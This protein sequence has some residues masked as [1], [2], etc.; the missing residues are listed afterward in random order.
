MRDGQI[1][2]PETLGQLIASTM[3]EHHI[4]AGRAAVIFSGEA[5]YLRTTT[6]P[7]MSEEQLAYNIPYEF[8][9]YITGELKD[10]VFD[11]A[12]V[13]PLPEGERA[14]APEPGEDAPEGEKKTEEDAGDRMQLLVSAVQKSALD[15]CRAALRKAGLRL[16]KAAPVECAYI[17]L[18]RDHEKRTGVR[19]QE[20][21]ILDLGYRVVRMHLFRGPRH[22]ATRGLEIGLSSLNDVIAEQKGVDPRLAHTYLLTNFEDVQN[23]D[24]CR[25]AYDNISV[26]LM[27][28][29]NFYRFSNPDSRIDTCWLAGGG[30]E[31]P[32]LR[33]SIRETL[34]IDV[35]IADELV[36]N[37]KALEDAYDYIQAIGITMD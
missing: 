35:R 23:S 3:R 22:L 31:I 33:D 28:A 37:G 30:A 12:V 29:L 13:P 32:A 18:I 5:T 24:Y 26:E 10:Y 9:D 15:D 16:A 14:G 11:Y 21:C 7:R 34:D 27:R 4:R 20:Y 2:S 6:M 36:S 25:A 17:G 8:S 1:T 19:D